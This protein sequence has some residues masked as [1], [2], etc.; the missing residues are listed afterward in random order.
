MRDKIQT[1]PLHF[2]SWRIVGSSLYKY[3]E[4]NNFPGLSEGQDNWKRVIPK[5]ERKEIL[6]R[7]HDDPCS[8]HSGIFKTFERV[9]QHYYWPKMKAGISKYVR[10]CVI[11]CKN[12]SEQKKPAGLLAPRRVV[13]RPFQV[14]SCDLIGPLPRSN[15][16]F[17]FILVIKDDIQPVR[18]DIEQNV[19]ARDRS[20]AFQELY[21]EVKRRLEKAAEKNKRYYDLRHR[22]VT[23]GLGARVYRKNFV[24]SDAAKY[25]SSKLAP[26]YVGPFII[27]KKVSP[28]T[29]ELKDVDGR[30]RETWHAKDL[31]PSPE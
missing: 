16:G 20:G 5:G 25:Y 4:H 7:C 9:S 27:S 28:W 29:Y 3:V 21:A 18:F 22:D 30:F 10:S 14:V 12:K 31:K 2:P 8:G 15:R 26:K 19:L 13:D 23:Y 1:D 6:L 24:L 11:C 17:K